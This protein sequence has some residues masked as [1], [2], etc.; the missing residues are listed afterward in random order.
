MTDVEAAEAGR[1]RPGNPG[2]QDLALQCL[3]RV[4]DNAVDAEIP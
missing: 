4:I 3:A 1:L 2:A